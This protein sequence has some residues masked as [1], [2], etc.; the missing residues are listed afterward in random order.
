M[1]ATLEA[2]VTPTAKPVVKYTKEFIK[3]K[4]ATDE[5]WAMRG[6]MRIFEFQTS[7]EQSVDQTVEQNNV[8]FPHCHAEIFS[9]FAKQYQ[10]RG[11]LSPKQMA[12]V[13]RGMPRY[14]SQLL[15]IIEGKQ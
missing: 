2:P 3:E 8:G 10:Q 5:R 15:R 9:S 12:I 14:A 13:H 6:L 11:Y 7:Q 1:N 4:L